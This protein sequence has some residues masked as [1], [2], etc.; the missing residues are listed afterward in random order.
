MFW[1]EN[2][3]N[4]WRWNIVLKVEILVL[5]KYQRV[6]YQSFISMWKLHEIGVGGKQK[7][8]SK[9]N[10]CLIG[11]PFLF[12]LLV[13]FLT[14]EEN[15]YSRLACKANIWFYCFITFTC[16]RTPLYLFLFSSLNACSY[17]PDPQETM[18]DSTS[19]IMKFYILALSTYQVLVA[20]SPFGL[21][22]KY[23]NTR[24]F[25]MLW[26]RVERI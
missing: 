10:Y 15:I 4:P 22:G 3:C 13:S 26:Y 18:M 1:L 9:R 8:D 23:A 7:I 14:L 17:L 16:S 24:K 25:Y 19:S 6:L 20:S 2:D 12:N 5:Y 21:S 11:V